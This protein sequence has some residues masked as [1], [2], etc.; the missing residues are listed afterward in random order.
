MTVT[1]RPAAVTRAATS[2]SA[3]TATRSTEAP[4]ADDSNAGVHERVA[5]GRGGHVRRGVGQVAH[6]G[7]DAGP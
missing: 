4:R 2:I 6:H 5:R 3:S 1:R 7:I